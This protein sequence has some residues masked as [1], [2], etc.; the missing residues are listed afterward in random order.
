MST[1]HVRRIPL[2][3][4]DPTHSE[5]AATRVH[6]SP[7]IRFFQPQTQRCRPSYSTQN[8][9][10]GSSCNGSSSSGSSSMSRSKSSSASNTI[11]VSVIVLRV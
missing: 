1:C 4:T 10:N 6:L 9:D 11:V 5:I 2:T 3:P 8:V 7:K